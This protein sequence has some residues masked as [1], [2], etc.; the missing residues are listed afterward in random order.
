[1]NATTVISPA[2]EAVAAEFPEAK[3]L[4]VTRTEARQGFVKGIVKTGALIKIYA[5][6]LNRD[7]STP[8]TPWYDLKGK[9]KGDVNTERAA[10][11]AEMTSAGFNKGTIDV[12]WQRVKEASGRVKVDNKVS[13]GAVDVDAKTLAELKTMINRIFKAEEEGGE[14]VASQI[15]GALMDAYAVMGGN[16]MDLG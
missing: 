5:A 15:K 16:E 7:L 11:V 8:V 12:Y 14:F 2:A 10:F 3:A 1:M 13:G 9:L 4:L 6:T